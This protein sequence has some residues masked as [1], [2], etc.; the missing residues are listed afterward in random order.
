[1]FHRLSVEG[2]GGGV[3]ICA[4]AESIFAEGAI[5]IGAGS[6]KDSAVVQ[7]KGWTGKG[8]ALKKILDAVYTVSKMKSVVAYSFKV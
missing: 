8:M 6:A 1:M 4:A 5:R 7:Y 2:A 3:E